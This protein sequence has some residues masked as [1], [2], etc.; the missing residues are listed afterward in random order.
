MGSLG[1]FPHLGRHPHRTIEVGGSR[2]ERKAGELLGQ[3]ERDKP[4]PYS[5]L[6][7]GSLSEYTAVLTDSD[8]APTTAT[9]QPVAQPSQ[10][11]EVLEL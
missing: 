6:E 11:A 4:K 5:R 9:S 7:N 8:I 1:V 2:A 10:Y 3:L